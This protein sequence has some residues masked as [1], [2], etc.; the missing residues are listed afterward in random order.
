[1]EWWKQVYIVWLLCAEWDPSKRVYQ[2][3]WATRRLTAKFPLR[4]CGH[5]SPPPRWQMP[6]PSC[7]QTRTCTHFL[8][9]SFIRTH[10]SPQNRGPYKLDFQ[11]INKLLFSLEIGPDVDTQTVMTPEYLVFHIQGKN[12]AGTDAA[13]PTALCMSLGQWFQHPPKCSHQYSNLSHVQSGDSWARE[14]YTI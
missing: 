7:T 3:S 10:S 6:P 4:C 1:M 9:Q 2:P 8:K 13:E 12:G 5:P 11:G 14:S